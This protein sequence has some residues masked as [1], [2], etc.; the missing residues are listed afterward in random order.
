MERA[1]NDGMAKA[2]EDHAN[3][4]KEEITRLENKVSTLEY[5]LKQE[6]QAGNEMKLEFENY[7]KTAVVLRKG[8]SE[9][10]AK[11]RA[12]EKSRGF[13]PSDRQRTKS[14]DFT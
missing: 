11:A 13:T 7:K 6:K 5:K 2:K 9:L 14:F 4:T 1:F 3:D 10:I 8:E 12:D